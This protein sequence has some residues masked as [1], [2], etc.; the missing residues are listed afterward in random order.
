MNIR[1]RGKISGSNEDAYVD[2]V[3]VR[4]VAVVPDTDP[5]TPDPLVWATAPYATGKTSIDMTAVTASDPSGVE[6]YFD[7]TTGN[8]GGTDSG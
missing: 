2:V 5:P 3:E 8:P 6:Y 7:E 4:T 1:F